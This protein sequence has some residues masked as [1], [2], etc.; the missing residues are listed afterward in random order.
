MDALL[1]RTARLVGEEKALSLQSKRVAVFGVGG[2]GGYVAEAI[3]DRLKYSEFFDF[4]KKKIY[5]HFI[6]FLQR[7]IIG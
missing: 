5:N 1:E 4:V 7:N 3:K 2:V 6:V